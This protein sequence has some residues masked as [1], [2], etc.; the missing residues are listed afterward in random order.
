MFLAPIGP[1]ASYSHTQSPSLLSNH[2]SLYSYHYKAASWFG[3]NL[4]FHTCI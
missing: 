1:P 4:N 2:S 3:M